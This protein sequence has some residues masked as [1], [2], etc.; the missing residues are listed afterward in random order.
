MRLTRQKR[1]SERKMLDMAPMIDIIML[2]LIFFMC[3]TSFRA[4]EKALDAQISQTH[5]QFISSMPDLAPI[6][7]ELVISG[8]NVIIE[9]DS[10]LCADFKA[11]GRML[12]DRRRVADAEVIVRGA[13][14]VALSYMVAAVDTCYDAGLNKVALSTRGVLR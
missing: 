3:T 6:E 8:G 1:K 5:Q 12:K 14:D 7:I 4:P 11:L 13:G 9:C 10:Q 2:L